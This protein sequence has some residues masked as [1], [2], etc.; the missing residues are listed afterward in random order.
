VIDKFIVSDTVSNSLF[1]STVANSFNQPLGI[2]SES[3]FVYLVLAVYQADS[4]SRLKWLKFDTYNG[5]AVDSF[6]ST[7]QMNAIYNYA[8]I[9]NNRI[10]V[11]GSD[12]DGKKNWLFDIDAK[13]VVDWQWDFSEPFQFTVYNPGQFYSWHKDGDSDHFGIFR[14]YIHG[15][16]QQPLKPDGKLPGKYTTNNNMVG[17]VR[18]ISLTINLNEPGD[19][20]GGNLKFD[21]GPHVD[22]EQYHECVEIRPQGSIVVFPGFV[23]HCV[24]PVTRGTRYSLVLWSLGKPWK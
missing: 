7:S 4:S 14:R 11:N 9:K 16:T 15:I 8:E 18:K 19:Y 24:T 23:N 5:F 20:D 10:I 3:Q 22:G 21:F 17:K 13:T 2:Y 6:A 1:Y 12:V